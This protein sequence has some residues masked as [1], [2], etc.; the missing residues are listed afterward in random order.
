MVSVEPNTALKLMTL[1]SRPELTSRVRH[2]TDWG[3]QVP[4]KITILKEGILKGGVG[5][6][7]LAHLVEHVT[8]DLRVEFKPHAG[9]IDY[10][11]I[12]SLK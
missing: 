4:P 12:K 3:T 1:R 7:W 8:F 5:G 2:L 10:L 11:K 9:Y 6:A